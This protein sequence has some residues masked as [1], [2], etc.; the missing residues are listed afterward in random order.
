V[1]TQCSAVAFR[2]LQGLPRVQKGVSR[3]HPLPAL[4]VAPQH[5]LLLLILKLQ[6]PHP[7]NT[8]RPARPTC[9]TRLVQ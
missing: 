4:L 2:L 9:D 1:H 3:T 7:V 8:H 5:L 6:I